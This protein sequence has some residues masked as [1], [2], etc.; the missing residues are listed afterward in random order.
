MAKKLTE[1]SALKKK[2]QALDLGDLNLGSWGK[3]NFSLKEMIHLH[4]FFWILRIN[5]AYIRNIRSD[6]DKVVL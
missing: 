6:G 3:L 1:T 2:Q 5:L 4:E